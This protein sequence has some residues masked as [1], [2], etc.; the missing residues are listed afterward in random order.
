MLS[1]KEINNKT[2][3]LPDGIKLYETNI[4]TDNGYKI[5]VIDEN[6]KDDY[7]KNNFNTIKD[8]NKIICVSYVCEEEDKYKGKKYKEFDLWKNFIKSIKNHN[9]NDIIKINFLTNLNDKFE[10][11]AKMCINYRN[12]DII[13]KKYPIWI[14]RYCID[15][16]NSIEKNKG[17][18]SIYQ[19]FSKCNM[20]IMCSPVMYLADLFLNLFNHRKPL[21]INDIIESKNKGKMDDIF[22]THSA[23][24]CMINLYTKDFVEE[25]FYYKWESSIWTLQEYLLNKNIKC[26]VSEGL[27]NY[28][29]I[30]KKFNIYNLEDTTKNMEELNISELLYLSTSRTS[31]I[32]E[33]KIY[34]L[35]GLFKNYLISQVPIEYGKGFLNSWLQFIVRLKKLPY[36][37]FCPFQPIY[38]IDEISNY[39]NQRSNEYC[40]NTNDYN[41]NIFRIIN[42]YNNLMP[43]N[44]VKDFKTRLLEVDDL[45]NDIWFGIRKNVIGCCE[46]CNNSIIE[47][48][49][50]FCY[51][52]KV[53]HGKINLCYVFFSSS[54]SKDIFK[55][56]LSLKTKL[57]L[58][59]SSYFYGFECSFIF[60]L[61]NI[62]NI[63]K[64]NLD[65]AIND[66]D[67]T[68]NII[69]YNNNIKE[70]KMHTGFLYYNHNSNIL[71]IPFL[72]KIENINYFNLENKYLSFRQGK[73]IISDDV[74]TY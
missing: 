1:N 50:P 40:N 34:G 72:L 14:D 2:Y 9:Q 18:Q 27:L 32:P 26:C 71:Y 21:N 46:F 3:N 15:Q 66:T 39:F 19:L 8:I 5:K 58:E 47:F 43:G 12:E 24:T 11:I 20:V 31:S 62:S 65:N 48:D 16:N 29:E 6:G 38:S 10:G 67:D 51:S 45:F 52:M 22:W 73:M 55:K 28:S 35:L 57:L 33:D 42:I 4:I 13:L 70:N 59:Y 49:N 69:I 44:M 23:L 36:Q 53:L 60:P 68:Y 30:R 61:F 25:L 41:F 56:N 64:Y 7:I 54:F 63:K 74:L 37:F 17:I